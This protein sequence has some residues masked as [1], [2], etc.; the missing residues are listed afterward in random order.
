MIKSTPQP[1][2]PL[3]K[4]PVPNLQALGGSQR[5]ARGLRRSENLF[6]RTGFQ[7]PNWPAPRQSVNRLNQ[8]FPNFLFQADPFELRKITTDPHVLADV[9][10]GCPVDRYTKLQIFISEQILVDFQYIPVAYETTRCII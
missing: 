5:E 2:Q 7:N 9:S 10:T 8:G 1:V 3:E 6:F 4:T